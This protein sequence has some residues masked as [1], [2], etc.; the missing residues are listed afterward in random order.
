MKIKIKRILA[1]IFP[2]YNLV[3]YIYGF[4]VFLLMMPYFMWNIVSNL[5]ILFLPFFLI[6]GYLNRRHLEKIDLLVFPV[7]SLS[8]LYLALPNELNSFGII[9]TQ[10]LLSFLIVDREKLIE[11]YKCFKIILVVL[12]CF[13]LVNYFLVILS[14]PLNYNIIEPLNSLK[15]GVYYQQYPFLVVPVNIVDNIISPSENILPRF[16]GVFDEPGVV[17]T[18]TGMM[19]FAERC[20]LKNKGNIILLIA[21][22]FSFS[23]FFFIMLLISILLFTKRRIIFTVL[24]MVSLSYILTKDDPVV[25]NYVWS[26]FEIENGKLKG[27]D[28]SE[29]GLDDYFKSFVKSDNF[30]YGTWKDSYPGS[31]SY[32]QFV[33]RFGFI[34]TIT[35][36]SLFIAIAAQI[37]KNIKGVFISVFLFLLLMYQRPFIFDPAYFF[38]V[39][40]SFVLIGQFFKKKIDD[41]FSL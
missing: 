26:R 36:L 39:I 4:C 7:F 30:L 23:L 19:L 13:S 25:D 37:S 1:A 5:K 10:M 18:F 15:I 29:E 12:F 31:A 40:S 21:G 22:V 32:K 16:C 38:L 27:D 17:G 24:L 11:F 41:S 34:F 9:F 28:R 35:L 14:V 20:N 6:I 8:L 33:I 2:K 3:S